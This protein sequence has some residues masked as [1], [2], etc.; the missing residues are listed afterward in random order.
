[1]LTTLIAFVA[2]TGPNGYPLYVVDSQVVA[3][4]K[5]SGVGACE[6]VIFTTAPNPLYVCYSPEQVIEKIRKADHSAPGAS[7]AEPKTQM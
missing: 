5:A 7:E 4:A 2:L 3:V 1:M 6:T